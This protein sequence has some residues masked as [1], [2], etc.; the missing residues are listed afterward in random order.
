MRL[1]AEQKTEGIG[2]VLAPKYL[3]RVF[4]FFLYNSLLFLTILN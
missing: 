2:L 3:V 1:L 4:M